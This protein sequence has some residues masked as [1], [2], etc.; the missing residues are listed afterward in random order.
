[1]ALLGDFGVVIH[2]KGN[3]VS[4]RV[5]NAAVFIG[6]NHEAELVATALA[7]GQVVHIWGQPGIGKT[8]LAASVL[9]G[10]ASSAQV[11]CTSATR[12]APYAPFA[13]LLRRNVSGSRP[14]VRNMIVRKLNGAALQ[15]DDLQWVDDASLAVISDLAGSVP[16]VLTSR[17]PL[18]ATLHDAQHVM[19]MHLA[20]LPP[21]DI[22]TLIADL[23][24][25]LLPDQVLALTRV[26]AGNPGLLV[27]FPLLKNV[28]SQAS[29]VVVTAALLARVDDLNEEDRRNLILMTLLDRPTDLAKLFGS[30]RASLDRL[31]AQSLAIESDGVVRVTPQLFRDVI[32]SSISPSERRE[33]H[34]WLAERLDSHAEAAWHFACAG[35]GEQ[36]RHHAM[37][38]RANTDDRLALAQL[39]LLAALFAPDERRE[40]EWCDG[41]AQLI[42]AGKANR[43][44]RL[45]EPIPDELGALEKA[46][47]A[48]L[49]ANASWNLGDYTASASWA[50]LAVH[51][52]EGTNS[53]IEARAK[54]RAAQLYA[55]T[56]SFDEA[57]FDQAQRAVALAVTKG[58]EHDVIVSLVRFANVQAVWGLPEWRTTIEDARTRAATAHDWESWISATEVL[59]TGLWLT[60]RVSEASRHA[61]DA[62]DRITELDQSN[63]WHG[64]NALGLIVDSLCAGEP[65]RVAAMAADLLAS[66]ATF[67]N[68]IFAI[69]ALVLAQLDLGETRAAEASVKLLDG[70]RI[71]DP[72]RSIAR[73]WAKA[74]AAFVNRRHDRVREAAEQIGAYNM[75]ALP[76]SAMATLLR[77]HCDVRDGLPLQQELPII[78]PRAF[79]GATV[80]WQALHLVARDLDGALSMFRTACETWKPF[81]LR[82]SV[83]CATAVAE[84]A[85]VHAV[86]NAS[87]LIAWAQTERQAAGLVDASHSRSRVVVGPYSL[88]P[89]QFDVMELVATGA[90]SAEIAAQLGIATST[91]D[92]HIRAV[93][94]VTGAKNRKEAAR[95]IRQ[96]SAP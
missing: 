34:R 11:A 90:A 13:S 48:E 43:A 76:P 38:N 1:M 6:R 17:E 80:E 57:Q 73:L 67:R 56:A 51:Y 92:S 72:A 44:L 87:E 33:C 95:R 75:P 37:S 93:I 5:H 19:S 82:A 83:R 68:R 77:A 52:C 23:H 39:T 2:C 20:P 71:N 66:N 58:S 9:Q 14:T 94:D 91:V 22:A 65:T 28:E 53:D 7:A 96:A 85:K 78:P 47:R 81:N 89:R 74:E 64:L 27:H 18:P 26:A 69:S 54:A 12:H 70:E 31:I 45:V 8:A 15:I 79:E 16:M 41:I 49:A 30:E 86:T 21:P 88:T 55:R 50:Q 35:D 40:A 63:S 3:I 24:P 4:T 36:A 10:H 25:G 29:M 59:V 60:G 61:W 46:R 32:A 42:A 62:T 84:L